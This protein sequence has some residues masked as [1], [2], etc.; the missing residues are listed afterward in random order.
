MVDENL[1]D[2]QQAEL[3]K[4][5]WR[6]N[7]LFLIGGLV[8]G[9]CGLFGWQAWQSNQVEIS[10]EAS[11][12]FQ[13]LREAS[14]QQ[15][16]NKASELH[17]LIMKDYSGT[18]YADSAEL[19]LAASY[20]KQA[21]ADKAA[22]VLQRLADQ[23]S[24][25]DIRNIAKLRLGRVLLQLEDY[26]RAEQVAIYAKDDAYTSVFADLRGDLAYAQG[27]I[28]AA[29]TAYTQ[30]LDSGGQSFSQAGYV[31]VKLNDLETVPEPSSEVVAE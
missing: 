16:F 5:W 15:R 9:I 23:T 29:R 17:E 2:E 22:D 31:R 27:N 7:G 14:E 19:T 13:E 21:N 4:N 12:A 24:N 3:V 6:E 25:D 30:A 28:E 1:T 10:Q 8:I 26:S 11:N 18:P 20:M